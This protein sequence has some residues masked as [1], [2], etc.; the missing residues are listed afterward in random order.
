MEY[1]KVI[2]AIEDESDIQVL[3]DGE[4]NGFAG[5]VLLLDEGHVMVSVDIEGAETKEVN[6]K[7][8]TSTQPMEVV[9]NV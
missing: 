7:D 5:H 1:L 9:I 6:L 3:I 8:T 2:T 4:K